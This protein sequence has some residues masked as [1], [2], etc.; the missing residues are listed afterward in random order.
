MIYFSA[1]ALTTAAPG[2]AG[3]TGPAPRHR[4][5]GPSPEPTGPAYCRWPRNENTAR[6]PAP[7]ERKTRSWSATATDA[8]DTLPAPAHLVGSAPSSP[9]TPTRLAGALPS[10]PGAN[11]ATA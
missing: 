8:P 10:A 2:P 5:P 1:R 4:G 7:G 6:C 3:G 9:A 11:P